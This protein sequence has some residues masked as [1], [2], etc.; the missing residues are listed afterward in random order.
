MQEWQEWI[1]VRHTSHQSATEFLARQVRCQP[2]S[3]AFI[4][5]VMLAIDLLM[6]LD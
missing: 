5:E 6:D 1:D 3:S 2:R 4:K